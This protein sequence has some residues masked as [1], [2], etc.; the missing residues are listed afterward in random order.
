[1]AQP[2]HAL[3]DILE[4]ARSQAIQE[5]ASA[6]TVDLVLSTEAL[7]R[8]AYLHIALVAVRDELAAHE[9]KVGGGSERG[10]D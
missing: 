1:M 8:V 3:A 2:V 4:A 10:L 6:D 9:P 5:L 7:Q